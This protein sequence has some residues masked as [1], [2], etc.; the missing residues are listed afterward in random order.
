MKKLLLLIPLLSSSLSADWA[1]DTFRF[2]IYKEYKNMPIYKNI[3]RPSNKPDIIDEAI[4]FW[5][6][7]LQETEKN[8]TDYKRYNPY[9]A[10]VIES[11]IETG[12]IAITLVSLPETGIIKM[13]LSLP[14]AAPALSS[15]PDILIATTKKSR[16]YI[17]SEAYELYL[18]RSGRQVT[19]NNTRVVQRNIFPHNKQ[20]KRL[21]Q[22]GHAP[23]GYDGKS[24]ELHHLK[25]DNKGT[26]IEILSKD[27]HQK[28]TKILH[29]SGK[30]STIK[31][32]KFD[33]FRVKYWK[34]RAK[35]I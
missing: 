6:P 32:S 35:S 34:E 4:I 33:T 19:F 27:E 25:Q 8:Y 28:H 12:A 30:P 10:A 21:M 16:L 2:Y 3:T 14:K 18:L 20:N 9:R 17:T 29:T 31:R 24:V 15:S 22:N 7:L 5:K 1:D 11:L 13:T 23:I 26:L